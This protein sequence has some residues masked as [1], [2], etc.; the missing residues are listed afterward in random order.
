MPYLKRINSLPLINHISYKYAQVSDIGPSWSSCQISQMGVQDAQIINKLENKLLLSWLLFSSFFLFL[1]YI[2]TEIEKKTTPS[3]FDQLVRNCKWGL[4]VI[5][6]QVPPNNVES[7][8]CHD[9]IESSFKHSFAI[10]PII[11][12]S[13]QFKYTHDK[14]E[15][16]KCLQSWCVDIL[17]G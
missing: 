2:L 10:S 8:L 15:P 11:C 6:M 12:I 1:Y 5:E 7:V 14:A 16:S 4:S 13:R 3:H 9:V 17:P